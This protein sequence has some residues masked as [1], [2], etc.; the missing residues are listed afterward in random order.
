MFSTNVLRFSLHRTKLDNKSLE[1]VYLTKIK[2][3]YLSMM[4]PNSKIQS[5]K[6]TKYTDIIF[7]GILLLEFL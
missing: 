1:Y 7:S 6:S 3:T 4:I 2:A 5:C